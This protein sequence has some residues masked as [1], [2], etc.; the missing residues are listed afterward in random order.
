MNDDRIKYIIREIS[1]RLKINYVDFMGIYF[2][3]SRVRGDSK[4]DSDYDLLFVFNRNVNWKFKEEIRHII[5][6]YEDKYDIVLDAKIISSSEI[7]MNRMPLIQDIKRYG[8]FY[9][10]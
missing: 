5:Y 3:G 6:G 8:I 4:S 9:G 10:I 1:D 7:D 2:Y